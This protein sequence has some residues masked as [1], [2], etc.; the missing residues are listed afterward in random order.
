VGSV[1]ALKFNKSWNLLA[2]RGSEAMGMK[3]VPFV[4]RSPEDLD[5]VLATV[6]G[7]QVDTIHAGVRAVQDP[8]DEIA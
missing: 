3:V 1:E 2:G 8:L 6:A 5:S 4:L 7:A